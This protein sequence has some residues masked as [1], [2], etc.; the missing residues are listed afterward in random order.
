MA[1]REFDNHPDLELLAAH[2]AGQ[3][4]ENESAA[5]QRHLED[6]PFCRLELKRLKRFANIDADEELLE[7]AGWRRA[8]FALA[9]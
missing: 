1:E 8:E 4:A 5:I 6:C 9:S 3:S 7:D 2:A